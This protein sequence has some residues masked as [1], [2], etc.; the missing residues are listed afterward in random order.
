MTDPNQSID[1]MAETFC[2]SPP[3]QTDWT[4]RRNVVTGLSAKYYY[5]DREGRVPGRF[6]ALER[7]LERCYCS[8]AYLA[9]IAFAQS[10]V[11]T[12]QHKHS[13]GDR[14]AMDKFLEYCQDDVDWLRLRRND[15]LH[16]GRPQNSL[17]LASYE[18]DRTNL[19]VDARRAIAIVYHV[20][21]AF[22]KHPASQLSHGVSI[23]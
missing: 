8:G 19:E 10:I 18:S 13:G 20:A 15:L 11:E 12:L 22:V 14:T 6:S 3:S 2:I 21:R 23:P 9:C 5:L 1:A 17:N 4:E 7:E 16:V